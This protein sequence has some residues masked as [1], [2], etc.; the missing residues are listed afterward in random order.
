M[1]IIITIKNKVE[2]GFTEYTYCLFNYYQLLIFIPSSLCNSYLLGVVCILISSYFCI[3]S[4]RRILI[5]LLNLRKL[6]WMCIKR[7][8]IQKYS[9][10]LLCYGIVLIPESEL[11]VFLSL[12]LPL[13]YYYK[14]LSSC[15]RCTNGSKCVISDYP[16]VAWGILK[17]CTAVK[18]LNCFNEENRVNKADR[19]HLFFTLWQKFINFCWELKRASW[20]ERKLGNWIL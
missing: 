6:R 15:I 14:N 12:F 19:N 3:Y 4:L 10:L 1:D 8:R 2:A 13:H 11:P 7:P 18:D 9:L 17:P 20:H 16:P 5:L